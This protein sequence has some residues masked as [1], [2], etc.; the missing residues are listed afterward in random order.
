MVEKPGDLFKGVLLGCLSN[1]VVPKWCDISRTSV[2]IGDEMK[3]DVA[4]SGVVQVTAEGVN[5]NGDCG[6][7]KN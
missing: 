5:S 7:K 1:D 2:L 6:R 3:V 4:L